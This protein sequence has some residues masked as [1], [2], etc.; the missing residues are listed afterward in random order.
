MRE[1]GSPGKVAAIIKEGDS[2]DYGEF[3]EKM[4]FQDERVDN[5]R[6]MPPQEPC[7]PRLAC[8][9]QKAERPQ[10]DSGKADPSGIYFTTSDQRRS[11]RSNLDLL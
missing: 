11:P 4:D 10:C 5:E 9:T 1:L 3:T 7:G 6:Q 2:Q 8:W